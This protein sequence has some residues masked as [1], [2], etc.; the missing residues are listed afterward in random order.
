MDCIAVAVIAVVVL[1]TLV[2]I[3]RSPALPFGSAPARCAI[4]GVTPCTPH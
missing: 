3:A 4:S 2:L 1:L